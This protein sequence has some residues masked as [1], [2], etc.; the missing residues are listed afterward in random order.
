MS[1]LKMIKDLVI[2]Y[3]KTNYEEYLK[4]NSIN[5]IEDDKIPEVV[6][7]LYTE[8][9]EHLRGFILNSMREM[10]KS[11]YPGDLPINT[12]LNDVFQDDEFNKTKLVDE[13]KTYQS[14][15]EKKNV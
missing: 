6:D 2:F 12:I 7:G 10:L 8:K 13:I 9:K 14:L 1:S 5:K 4:S 15:K 11:D 3:I